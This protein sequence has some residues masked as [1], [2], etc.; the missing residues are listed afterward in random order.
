[1]SN[2][3]DDFSGLRRLHRD[4]AALRA[5]QQ[6]VRDALARHGFD[7]NQPRVPAGRHEGGQ[8]I[9]TGSGTPASGAAR[10]EVE[11]DRSGEESWRSHVSSYRDDGSLAEQRVFNRDGSRIVSEFDSGGSSGWDQRHIVVLPDGR[12]I[13]FENSGDVQRIYDENGQLV[14]ASTW[15]EAGPEPLIQQARMSRR[16]GDL[17]LLLPQGPGGPLP[18]AP[19]PGS[20]GVSPGSFDKGWAAAATTLFTWM[21]SRNR[22]DL[23]AVYGIKAREYRA[24]GTDEQPEVAWVGYLSR[25][26]VKKACDKI[27][28]VQ[29]YTDAS[30]KYVREK[31][32][33]QGPA[34]FGTKVHK[35][36]EN[37][38]N[39]LDD[40][41]FVAER[42]FSKAEA[43]TAKYIANNNPKYGEK[44]AVYGQKN[45]VR[46]DALRN[47][48]DLKMACIYDPKTG[49]RGLSSTRMAELALAVKRKFEWALGFIVI[50]IRPTRK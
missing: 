15:T 42:S 5:R 37:T 6:F 35:E 40:P 31:V 30:V 16:P 36:I 29:R 19:G 12:K 28:D 34:D 46:V 10:R 17:P 18:A 4:L 48:P 25:D 50:E 49:W 8:W 2:F 1:M 26:E 32:P 7:P 24:E 11:V 33:F 43:E 21:S 9:R 44:D 39:G 3:E 47:R 22:R 27:D 41:N 38:I 20:G 14:S 23:I 45:T 13:R